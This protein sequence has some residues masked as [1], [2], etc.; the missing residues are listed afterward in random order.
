MALLIDQLLEGSGTPL[1]ENGNGRGKAFQQKRLQEGQVNQDLAQ[2][3]GW[4][5][6]L[7]HALSA[8]ICF[9]RMLNGD[10]APS[11]AVVWS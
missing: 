8:G 10:R 1:E 2:E 11:T 3:S 7:F 9:I 6:G 4:V 5:Y